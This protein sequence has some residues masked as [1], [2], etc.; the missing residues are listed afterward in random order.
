M[1]ARKANAVETEHATENVRKQ[2]ALGHRGTCKADTQAGVDFVFHDAGLCLPL[3]SGRQREGENTLA[4]LNY[5]SHHNE[6]PFR[7]DTA[8]GQHNKINGTPFRDNPSP[9]LSRLFALH[10]PPQ[11]KASPA[12]ANGNL[13]LS[14]NPHL[15]LLHVSPANLTFLAHAH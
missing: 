15:H 9:N 2:S 14:R 1:L 3:E 10:L 4:S 8:D 13:S 7:R 12:E 6:Q 5:S 11:G